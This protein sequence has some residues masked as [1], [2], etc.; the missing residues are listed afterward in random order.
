MSFMQLPANYA[1]NTE[2]KWEKVLATGPEIKNRDVRKVTAIMLENTA[3]N[4]GG[5]AGLLTE[6]DMVN[7][8]YATTSAFPSSGTAGNPGTLSSFTPG[9]TDGIQGPYDARIAQ[10]LMPTV[11]RIFPELLAHET[12]AVQPM[13]G[14]VGIAIA[15]RFFMD[16]GNEIGWYDM[17]ST[18]TGTSG[19]STN[20]LYALYGTVDCGAA[21]AGAG[22]LSPVITCTA[23]D[24]YK[25]Y[26]T[27]NSETASNYDGQADTLANMEW[28][29]LGS[30]VSQAKV[31]FE[32]A[33]VEAKERKVAANWSYE[34]A[35][36][37]QKMLSLDMDAEMVN[38]MSFQIKAEIDRQL[39]SEMIKAAL[40][41]SRSSKWDPSLADGRNQMDRIATLATQISVKSEQIAKYSRRGPATFLIT[42]PTVVGLMARQT[43]F[44]GFDKAFQVEGH[45]VGV[46]LVGTTSAGSVKVFRD[47]FASEAN[48]KTYVLLGYKGAGFMDSGIVYCPYIPLQIARAIGPNNFDPRVGLRTRYAVAGN[49]FGAANY[50][51]F[52]GVDGL[53]TQYN[54]L[55]SARQ[56]IF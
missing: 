21:R 23:G 1:R 26:G 28:K 10:M 51:H 55:C 42:T 48:G 45:Q 15:L 38:A 31:K 14:P 6:A 37:V 3:Q 11:R 44:G 9:V 13:H 36:D 30:G 12:V 47:S 2:A 32:K 27:C 5:A 18:K 29:G 25:Y 56:F 39:V 53:T 20:D 34:I 41:G 54:L 50:Y 33:I 40:A 52:I 35:E 22:A 4:M 7:S 8:P 16:G 43:E 17:D 49:L 19:M 46:S 24:W